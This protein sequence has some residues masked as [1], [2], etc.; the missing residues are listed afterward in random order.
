MNATP[1][2]NAPDSVRL[3]GLA[4]VLSSLGSE[5]NHADARAR[6]QAAILAFGRRTI[7]RPAL[8]VLMQDAVALVGEI[9]GTGLAGVTEVVGNGQR[10]VTTVASLDSTGHMKNPVSRQ[11]PMNPIGSMAA[12]ALTMANTV[13]T[14]DLPNET[15]Y[16]DMFLRKLGIRSALCVPV[17]LNREPF[18]ALSVFSLEHRQ[19][20]A[21]DS[22]FAESISHLLAATIA[23]VHAEN[24]M[25][26]QKELA[27]SVLDSVDSLVITL[28]DQERL[29]RMNGA[30]EYLL[31]F[32]L[33]EV[34]GKTF[35]S[36]MLA[37]KAVEPFAVFFRE[38][39]NEG[40]SRGLEVELI[41]KDGS[42]R[43]VRLRGTRLAEQTR[44]RPTVLLCGVDRTEI[45]RL[46][47]EL[48]RA[49]EQLAG[50]GNA[51]P[52]DSRS[53]SQEGSLPFQPTGELVKGHEMRSSP[54]RTYQYRQLIA[55][56]IGD[57]LPPRNRFFE[58]VCE[59]ISAGGIA[60]YLDTPPDFKRVVV[61]LG[62]A[63]QLTFFTAN[64]ARVTEKEVDGRR[65][66]LVG[67][68]FTGRIRR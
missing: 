22:G 41:A 5:T 12:F 35:A 49:R 37:P 8:A 21:D 33:A 31:G 38:A 27:Q 6:R 3:E 17:H 29:L 65:Q 2:T 30:T 56:L 57:R 34:A 42:P 51:D 52:G 53:A 60:F 11:M 23:R 68:R 13:V 19:F 48:L 1:M 62:Q 45:A 10:L 26:R 44:S 32:S 39:I 61:G 46:A 50:N 15:A 25:A 24:E 20:D 14:S 58:V 7:A 16:Q 40:E 43:M 64:I 55:P 66:F 54:R 28:D 59:D 47:G 63:P 67:C 4:E 9:L 36:T 18:G